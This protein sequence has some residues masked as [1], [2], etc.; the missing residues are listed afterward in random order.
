MN[1]RHMKMY[2]RFTAGI[3]ANKV[4]EMQQC[5]SPQLSV[6]IGVKGP[7]GFKQF[8]EE[9]SR[10]RVA[11]PDFG[12]NVKVTNTEWRTM[13]GVNY[14]SV[15]YEMTVTF[16][17]PLCDHSGNVVLQPT[18]KKVTIVASDL[19]GFDP[20]GKIVTLAVSTYEEATLA[21]MTR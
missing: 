5:I 7:L 14:L 12:K 19:V 11:F 17:G 9:L 21:Q 10:Q 16:D 15:T 6:I 3:A 18:G 2:E 8:V 13:G 20:Q 4:R 1:P